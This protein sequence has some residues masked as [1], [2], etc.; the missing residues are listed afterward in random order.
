MRVS[1]WRTRSVGELLEPKCRLAPRACPVRRG[2]L[3]TRYQEDGQRG[4]PDRLCA[5]PD[6]RLLPTVGL[7]RERRLVRA[8]LRSVGAPSLGATVRGARPPAR[9]GLLGGPR[10]R[11]CPGRSRGH[12][13]GPLRGTG[14]VEPELPA[15]VAPAEQWGERVRGAGGGEREP[16]NRAVRAARTCAAAPAVSAAH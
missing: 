3:P 8:R 11:P 15:L 4:A 9:G 14:D 7:R 5:P 1:R 16:E 13:R 2:A 6:H 12:R 10:P